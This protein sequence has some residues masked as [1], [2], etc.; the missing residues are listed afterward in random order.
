MSDGG[1]LQ[2]LSGLDLALG[3]APQNCRAAFR[4][5]D[6]VDAELLHQDAIADGDAERAAA[7]ALA[8]DDHDDRHV[9][10]RHLAEVQRDRLGDAAFLGLD[11]GYA[12]GVS[13]K[14]ITGRWNFCASCHDPQR[15]AVALGLGVAEI[16]EDLL[17]GVAALLVADRQPP[18]GRGRSRSR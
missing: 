8:A 11:A 18:A 2:G 5:D 3:V 14:T 4:R 13:T 16:A 7:A 10:Q 17:L 6:A 9:E 1:H 12:A 15:L